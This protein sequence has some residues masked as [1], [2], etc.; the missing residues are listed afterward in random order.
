V[1]LLT[2]AVLAAAALAPAPSASHATFSAPQ[3]RLLI[4]TE[5]SGT[6]GLR[7]LGPGSESFDLIAPLGVGGSAAMSADGKHIALN[8]SIPI[9]PE[10]GDPG[11]LFSSDFLGIEGGG[12]IASD[13][14]RGGRPAWSPD[15]TKV[16]YA[17]KV[18]GKW[19]I[20]A[21]ARSGTDDPVN[22]TNDAVANDR[23]PRWAP[24]GHAIA[25]ESDRTGNWEVFSMAP[26]GTGQTD[27]TN[28]PAEDRLGDWSPGSDR[29]VFS[30][31]R[32]GGGD[33]YVM[34]GSGGVATQLTNGAGADTHAAWSPD[35]TTIAYS[36]DADGNA[37]VWELAPDG[38]NLRRVTNNGYVDLVQDWQPLQDTHPPVA[39]ALASTGRRRHTI[40][41]RYRVSEDSSEAAVLIDFSYQTKHGFTSAGADAVLNGVRPGHT[42]T[43]AFPASAVKGA[44]SSFRFCVQAFDGSINQSARSCARFRFLKPPKKR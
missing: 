3:Q 37:N 22:L 32:T 33:L 41:L 7:L 43:A 40:H 42:Y 27:L 26:N 19:N 4:L 18:N 38:T 34:P 10:S 23:N 16:A 6:F 30:S 39:R 29:L 9:D 11:E 5:A 35:G 21:A 1:R 36:N 24:D 25:F 15:G 31:T 28:N 2:I 44:P 14:A 13:T 20:F 12:L 8:F 17:A